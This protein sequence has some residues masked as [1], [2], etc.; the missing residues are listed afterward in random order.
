MSSTRVEKEKPRSKRRAGRKA[1]SPPPAA[2]HRPRRTSRDMDE[3]FAALELMP[4]SSPLPP[5]PVIRTEEELA[6]K[7]EGWLFRS[8]PFVE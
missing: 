8:V 4:T 7:A 2:A 5:R 1:K 6:A 3:L